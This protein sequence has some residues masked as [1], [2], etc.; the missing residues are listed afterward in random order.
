MVVLTLCTLPIVTDRAAFQK[1]LDVQVGKI[2]L[3][4]GSALFSARLDGTPIRCFELIGLQGEPPEVVLRQMLEQHWTILS[5]V[6]PVAGES[7][8]FDSMRVVV[9]AGVR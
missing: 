6:R 1:V 8:Y 7:V 3:P 4:D 9:V 5:A 2:K